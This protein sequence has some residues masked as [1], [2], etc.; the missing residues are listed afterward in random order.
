M[1]RR[2]LATAVVA[3][4]VLVLVVMMALLPVPYV[5]MSPGPTVDVLGRNGKQPIIEVSG[6]RTYPTKGELR[7]TTV[8]ETSPTRHLRLPEVM[9]AWFDPDRAVYPRDVIYPPDSSVQDVQQQ[10]TVAMVN[11]QDTAVAAALSE[12][13]YDLPLRVEVLAVTKGAPAEGRLEV[14]DRLLRVD[15]APIRSADQVTKALQDVGVGHTATFVV[16]RGSATRT[17]RITTE[18]SPDDKSR[19]VVGVQ[20]GTG[21]D[22]PFDVS[23]HLGQDIGGPSAGLMFSLGVYDLL[24]PGALTGGAEV[25]GTGTIDQRGHV[26]PIGGIQQKIVGAADAGATLFFVPPGDCGPA[27]H[28]HVDKDEI[29]LV[30]AATMHSAVESLRAYARD[31]S[32][33]L[34]ACR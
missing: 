24:T 33:D 12:L 29:R 6:H 8:S 27:L 2:T 22:F 23:V 5:A 18:A 26:G 19:A 3:A 9:W 11:S 7:L 31:R 16:R 21:Y 25:A 17:V 30:K 10:N 28:A 20:I 1:S 14:R 13:G 32:A 15:G 4:L 34:P